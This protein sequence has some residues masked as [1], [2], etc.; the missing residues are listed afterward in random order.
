M[1]LSAALLHHLAANVN[2][3]DLERDEWVNCYC[4]VCM[5]AK[6]NL[7]FVFLCAN[8]SVQHSCVSDCVGAGIEFSAA[9]CAICVRQGFRPQEGDKIFYEA[10]LETPNMEIWLT[11]SSGG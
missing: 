3:Y 2:I 9:F 5:P 11:V 8:I 10:S 6:S 4:R 1:K 7:F